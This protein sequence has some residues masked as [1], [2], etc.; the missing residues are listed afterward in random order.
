M[1]PKGQFRPK[2]Y[3]GKKFGM[4]TPFERTE[5]TNP[6]DGSY[7][8]KVKCDCGNEIERCAS[9]FAKIFSCGCTTRE[10]SGRKV[11]IDLSSY[12]NKMAVAICKTDRRCK[13]TRNVI[14]KLQCDCGKT[15]ERSSRSMI[16]GTVKSCGCKTFHK[17][18][19]RPRIPEKGS[20]VNQLFGVYRRG[21]ESRDLEFSISKLFCRKMFESDCFYCGIEPRKDKTSPNLSGQY[22]WNGI[23]RIDSSKGY[24]EENCVPCCTQCNFSKRS[25]SIDSFKEW[26]QRIYSH[27]FEKRV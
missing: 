17:P 26:I 16:L 14:W 21:A 20:H 19:G 12:K 24:T 22:L 27:L 15:F 9:R 11:P 3:L 7:I 23:D 13:S 6:E 5:R 4:I 18:S 25:L 8:W 1:N 2:N 10:N